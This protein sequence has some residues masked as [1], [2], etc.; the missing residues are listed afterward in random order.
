MLDG[1]LCS[2]GRRAGL[3]WEKASCESDIA[4]S[5]RLNDAAG[6]GRKRRYE[7]VPRLGEWVLQFPY[8]V[9][10]GVPR[11]LP[12]APAAF[13][14]FVRK[15]CLP[16]LFVVRPS[17]ITCRYLSRGGPDSHIFAVND[18]AG[19]VLDAGDGSRYL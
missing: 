8:P 7:V 4:Q 6:H 9:N 15:Y 10:R 12:F 17:Q 11:Y 13:E 18:E 1:I 14:W 2:S 19:D 3:A 16:I 5:H